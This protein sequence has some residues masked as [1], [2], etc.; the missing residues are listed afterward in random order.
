[1]KWH[2]TNF[3]WRKCWITK[4]LEASS[5]CFM[6]SVQKCVFD[7]AGSIVRGDNLFL[8][9]HTVPH[10]RFYYFDNSYLKIFQL[11]FCFIMQNLGTLSRVWN[12]LMSFYAL[13]GKDWS[14]V[15]SRTEQIQESQWTPTLIETTGIQRSCS[16][17]DGFL[18]R[19]LV[20]FGRYRNSM[21]K[22][23]SCAFCM[24]CR[25]HWTVISE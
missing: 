17:T 9:L 23:Q 11:K 21:S 3:K 18:S 15:W 10:H 7:E 16:R 4:Q 2:F 14:H 1:M 19:D 12:P 25:Y 20:R 6:F 13:Y 5:P 8:K 22:L 24:P